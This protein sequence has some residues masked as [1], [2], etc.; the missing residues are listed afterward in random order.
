MQKK[1]STQELTRFC[2]NHQVP[3][4]HVK[5]TLNTFLCMAFSWKKQVFISNDLH[6]VFRQYWTQCG[7]T[8]I[9]IAYI[10]FIDLIQQV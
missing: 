4:N 3:K 9:Y 5:W 10:K 2:I 8:N 1:N 7:F 6:M